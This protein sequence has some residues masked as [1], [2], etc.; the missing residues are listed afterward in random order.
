MPVASV[1][2]NGGIIGQTLD[3]GSTEQYIAGTTTPS[4]VGSA[5]ASGS[6]SLSLTGITGLQE[7]DLVLF[8][9]TDD[10]NTGVR[11]ITSSGWTVAVQNSNNSIQNIV[12]YKIMGSTV[13]TS[14][15]VAATVDALTATA[16]R[17]VEY[18]ATWRI[19]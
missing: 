3:L 14:V 17:G 1:Y 9:A 13:D 8:W 12:A 2:E 11:T 19:C 4:Y 16:W 7:G 10:S 6:S 18:G 15:S 5:S